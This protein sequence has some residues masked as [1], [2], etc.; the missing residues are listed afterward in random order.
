[1]YVH[2]NS[3]GG[4]SFELFPE[5]FDTANIDFGYFCCALGLKDSD[6]PMD[7]FMSSDFLYGSQKSKDTSMLFSAVQRLYGYK[8]KDFAAF[9]KNK[10]IRKQ[11][12]NISDE[13]TFLAKLGALE[14]Q[15]NAT[16]G[17]GQLLTRFYSTW[18][19]EEDKKMLNSKIAFPADYYQQP[20]KDVDDALKRLLD[21]LIKIRNGIGHAAMYHPLAMRPPEPEYIQTV[22]GSREY[23]I[24]L[25][26][27]FEELYSYTRK[28]MAAYWVAE[29]KKIIEDVGHATVEKIV[30]GYREENRRL[31]E[32][33]RK[34][35]DSTT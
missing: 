11:L 3:T 17:M 13:A 15:Y 32:A 35:K 16:Y 31:N 23:T 27:T 9:L 7:F 29:Y 33:N 22:K 12:L 25:F 4:N 26:L 1:M 18:L 28:A 5:V 19:H 8:H 30:E 2:P 34:A 21:F 24:L 6:R 14:E 20:A 10:S